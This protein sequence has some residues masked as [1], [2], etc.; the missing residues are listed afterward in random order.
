MTDDRISG[1]A[2]NIGGKVQEAYGTATGD[3]EQQVRGKMKQAEGTAQD[4]YGQA[5]DAAADTMDNVQRIA[6]NADDLLR[7][8]IEKQPYTVAVVALAAGWLLG[9]MSGRRY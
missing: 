8:Y 3:R 5:K 7:N 2:K 4:L 1:T 9:R 6:H